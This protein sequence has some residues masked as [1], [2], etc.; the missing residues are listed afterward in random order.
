MPNSNAQEREREFRAYKQYWTEFEIKLNIS[1]QPDH[2]G[3][4]LF[5][6]VTLADA[7]FDARNIAML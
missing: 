5:G 7:K 6:H 4:Y 3:S 1:E 2:R